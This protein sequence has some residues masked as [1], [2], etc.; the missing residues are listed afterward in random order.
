MFRSLELKFPGWYDI[1]EFAFQGQ[2]SATI[3]YDGGECM[4][5]KEKLM[6]G[7]KIYG[8][9]IK[10]V[11]NPAVCFLAKNS[12]LDFVMF[13]CEHAGYN[14]ET[15][16]NIFITGNAQGF[17]CFLR[18]PALAKDYISR[19][20]DQGAHG[21]MNPMTETAEM[22]RTLVKYSKYQPIGGRG[23]SGGIAHD[24]YV[25]GGKHIEVMEN[26]NNTVITIAQIETKLSVDNAEEI[27]AIEGIDVLLVGPNDLSISLGFPGDLFN[28]V[29]LEAIAHVGD[30]CK[31]YHKGFG[32]H[33]GAK[34]I[35]KFHDDLNMIMIQS[36]TDFLAAGFKNIKETCRNFGK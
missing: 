29:E 14:M 1:F 36:D 18:V 3:L 22:A 4:L 21:V 16:H 30:V 19:A 34:L 35:E 15:L 9:M 23:Y 6:S 7:Q 27:A 33:S 20:L 8:T 26:A 13:D 10:V 24:N 2:K 28:P 11:Q 5:L 32:L 25:T 17:D 31:K 12:G